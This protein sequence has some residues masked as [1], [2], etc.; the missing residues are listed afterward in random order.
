MEGDLISITVDAEWV[1]SPRGV[2]KE[3]VQAGHRGDQ[4]GDKKMK[5]KKTCERGVVNR[6]TSP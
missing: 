6:E 5:G 3:D 2:Q 1:V 4:E